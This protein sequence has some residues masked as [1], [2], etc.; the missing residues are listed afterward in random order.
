MFVMLVS[1]LL[2]PFCECISLKVKIF[3]LGCYL[4][5]IAKWT[6]Q[7]DYCVKKFELCDLF[8]PNFLCI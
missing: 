7:F 1:E 8:Q 5:K 6:T 4:I 2:S 3:P